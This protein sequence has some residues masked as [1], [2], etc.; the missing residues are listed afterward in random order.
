MGCRPSERLILRVLGASRVIGTELEPARVISDKDKVL[1]VAGC[2]SECSLSGA[3]PLLCLDAALAFLD[4]N[5][6][7]QG[8]FFS[9]SCHQRSRV[10]HCRARRRAWR[11][12]AGRD[13]VGEGPW[14]TQAR[15]AGMHRPCSVPFGSFM[16]LEPP[17]RLCFGALLNGEENG[18]FVLLLVTV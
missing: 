12:W 15:S 18:A 7:G 2:D 8:W 3:A 16:T 6:W 17:A 4:D 10:R 14:R 5:L 1:M 9:H 11:H 13:R